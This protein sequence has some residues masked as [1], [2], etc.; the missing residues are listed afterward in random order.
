M[1]DAAIQSCAILSLGII[2]DK[3]DEFIRRYDNTKYLSLSYSE[4]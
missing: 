1:V 4:N 2:F 3:T